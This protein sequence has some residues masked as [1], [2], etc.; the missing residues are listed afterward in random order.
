MGPQLYRCGNDIADVGPIGSARASMG[1]QLYRCGNLSRGI[2][3]H[4]RCAC[5]NGAAT[6]SLRKFS[7][8][9][10]CRG[11]STQASMGPQLYRC[12]NGGSH[13]K[14]HHT[15]LASMGPQ[16]YRCGN[17]TCRCHQFVSVLALQ[18]GRN[19]IVAEMWQRSGTCVKT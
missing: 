19:F 7:V 15:I 3:S 5:F 10:T 2:A 4:G 18:W 17:S 1:P 13:A 11:N 14:V 9:T 6:L 16:L 12:G 8:I